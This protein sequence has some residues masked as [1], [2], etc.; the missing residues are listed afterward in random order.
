MGSVLPLCALLLFE[1]GSDSP[2][3]FTVLDP[4]V[5]VTPPP[6][7]ALYPKIGKFLS[8]QRPLPLILMGTLDFGSRLCFLKRYLS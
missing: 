2:K 6:E 1:L 3:S 8:A 4:M 7:I 5:T